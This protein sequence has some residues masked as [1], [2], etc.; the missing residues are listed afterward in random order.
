MIKLFRFYCLVGFAI[1]C[2]NSSKPNADVGSATDSGVVT[3][4][5]G[6]SD[7]SSVSDANGASDAKSTSESGGSVVGDVQTPIEA[8][9]KDAIADAAS[10]GDAITPSE[11]VLPP[12]NVAFDYQLGGAYPPAASVK[13]VARD[14][15]EKPAAGLYNI[16]Y[17]NGFQAQP[18]E[19]D[20]WLSKHPDLVLRDS[21]GE[22]I[23]DQD[24]N[25][26]LLDVS[27]EPKR[28][29]LA[30]I[31]GDFIAGCADA[32]FVAVEIDNL[33]SYSRSGGRLN[34][35]D[36]VA[37]IKLLSDKAHTYGLAIAQKNA[38]E[39]V[40]RRAEMGTDFA[41]AEECTHYDECD[42]YRDGYGDHVLMIEYQRADFD[43]GC[44]QYP[45]LSI[46]LRDR[47]LVRSDQPDYVFEGC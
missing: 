31:M 11:L 1:A 37:F 12:V 19:N 43:K 25:E 33:D 29:S 42:V 18:D 13:I 32:G 17:V 45:G 27:T 26:M 14:R 15:K 21:S 24:W 6:S 9:E 35:D 16:C 8:G 2:S 39:L 7:T 30:E 41:V 20:F 44:A 4:S 23:I 3:D 5:S 46:V 40:T 34:P 10:P 28:A 36:A 38:S 22:P 47:D